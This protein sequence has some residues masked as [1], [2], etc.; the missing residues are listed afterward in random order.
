L[1]KVIPPNFV[2][3]STPSG[4]QVFDA[5]YDLSTD[6]LNGRVEASNLELIEDR[7]ITFPY[8]QQNS[9][10]GGGMVAGTCNLDY[11]THATYV[12]TSGAK[13]GDESGG[14]D[15]SYSGTEVPEDAPAG[16]FSAIPGASITFHLPFKAYVLLT[17]Q[18]TWTSDSETHTDD[19]HTHIRLFVDGKKHNNCNTRRVGRTMFY[20]NASASSSDAQY[21]Y[22]R[23]R[24]KGRYWSGHKWI[25]VPLDKGFHS[26]SLRVTQGVKVKQARVRARSM[27]YMFFKA[28]ND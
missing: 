15:G 28:K 18:V 2:D 23:D 1:A 10:S 17:W 19:G 9:A 4:E 5:I 8:L 22:L 6:V 3:G 27:K 21:S 14:V 16:M 11:F 20:A 26:V 13:E 7:S 12:Y 24:Y 25:S